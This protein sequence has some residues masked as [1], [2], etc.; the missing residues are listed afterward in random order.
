MVWKEK[1]ASCSVLRSV[2]RK[3]ASASCVIELHNFATVAT[4]KHKSSQKFFVNSVP[5]RGYCPP[6][7][8][9]L[10]PFRKGDGSRFFGYLRGPL[11]HLPNALIRDCQNDH[12]CSNSAEKQA[13]NAPLSNTGGGRHN[14]GC[15]DHQTHCRRPIRLKQGETAAASGMTSLQAE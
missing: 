4:N 3:K 8:R 14:A 5:F 1:P 6:I 9:S 7:T 15:A 2:R 10:S 11:N 13:K 12:A